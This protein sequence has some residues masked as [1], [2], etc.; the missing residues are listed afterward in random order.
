MSEAE[1]LLKLSERIKDRLKEKPDIEVLR[2]PFF[3]YVKDDKT[4][5]HFYFFKSCNKLLLSDE[6]YKEVYKDEKR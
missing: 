5:G 4:H 3:P 2:F 6:L 1:A